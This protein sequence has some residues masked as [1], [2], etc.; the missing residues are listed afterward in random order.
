MNVFK[1]FKI[2]EIYQTKN[3]NC[4]NFS[5]CKTPYNVES[6]NIYSWNFK[7]KILIV[8]INLICDKTNFKC[9]WMKFW[10]FNYNIIG[11]T[12]EY[13]YIH[14]IKIMFNKLS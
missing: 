1:N 10:H 4:K 2:G 11:H 3:K 14:D 5:F 13:Y 12:N 7:D 9:Y 6:S 8:D